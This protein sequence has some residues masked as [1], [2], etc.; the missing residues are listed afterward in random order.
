MPRD[1]CCL[2]KESVHHLDRWWA[3][4]GTLALSLTVPNQRRHHY[5]NR[6]Y[7]CYSN[8]IVTI[9]VPLLYQRRGKMPN[10]VHVCV[11]VC[12]CMC[13]CVC[14]CVCVCM[15]VCVT[16]YEVIS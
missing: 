3:V 7:I 9:N 8:A 12:V 15:C 4:F 1:C 6:W 16:K 13:V 5:R 2:V 11:C 10:H 14:V